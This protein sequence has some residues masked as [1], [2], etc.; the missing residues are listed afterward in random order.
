MRSETHFL[1]NKEKEKGIEDYVERVTTVPRT[2]VK[3]TET[4]IKQDEEETRNA[5]YAGVT[6]RQPEKICEEMMIRMGASLIDVASSDD[7]DD[8]DCGG[9]EDKEL[10]KLSEDDEPGWAVVTI[11]KTVQHG[12]E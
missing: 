10:G 3:D 8:G 9:S 6:T 11:F 1:S 4:T 5:D 7:E 2:R 12:I